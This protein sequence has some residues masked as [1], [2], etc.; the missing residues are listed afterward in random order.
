M[1][2]IKFGRLYLDVILITV[3]LMFAFVPMSASV[4][5]VIKKQ[6]FVK[7]R[8]YAIIFNKEIL[9]NLKAE[10]KNKGME[11]INKISEQNKSPENLF[12]VL[13][14]NLEKIS[15]MEIFNSAESLNLGF[16]YKIDIVNL[17]DN[18][19]IS[20]ESVEIE[21]TYDSDYQ[22][23]STYKNQLFTNSESRL[24][25][26]YI[27]DKENKLLSHAGIIV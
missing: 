6:N 25:E 16:R 24:V 22:V 27:F 9:Y 8:E 7:E 17:N 10:L 13:E 5:S 18:S 2:K 15:H 19:R 11:N 20:F 23:F 12:A 4:N 3:L 21:N 14:I 26:V 1:S